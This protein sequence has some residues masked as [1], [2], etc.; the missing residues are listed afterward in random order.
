MFKMMVLGERV[1]NG[2][3]EFRLFVSYYH[4]TELECFE[5][6]VKLKDNSDYYI[7]EIHVERLK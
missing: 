3:Y 7:K 4:E 6:L 2:K 1:R 5:W